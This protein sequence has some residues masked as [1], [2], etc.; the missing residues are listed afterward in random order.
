ML[1]SWS[2]T[3]QTPVKPAGEDDPEDVGQRGVAGGEEVLGPL[4]EL[5]QLPLRHLA[6][7]QQV[8]LREVERPLRGEAFIRCK[9]GVNQV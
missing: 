1:G 3:G 2:N 8:L 6:V 7:L 5:V 9:S 4:E